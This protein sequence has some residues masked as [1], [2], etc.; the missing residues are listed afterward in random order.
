[1]VPYHSQ[2]LQIFSPIQYVVFFFFFFLMVPFALQRLLSL[3]RFHLF[4]FVYFLYFRRWIQKDISAIYVRAFCLF[5]SRS[6]T[7]SGLTSSSL[8]HRVYFCRRGAGERAGFTLSRVAAR[9]ARH[10][11]LR[12]RSSP[13]RGPATCVAGRLAMSARACSG[14]PALLADLRVRFRPCATR[15]GSP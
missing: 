15:P 6:L 13:P 12:R 10:R 4:I 11:L 1:M 8:I 3:I 7:V 14:P 2:H 9:F 5:S